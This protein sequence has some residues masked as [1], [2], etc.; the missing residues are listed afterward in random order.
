[1]QRNVW[2][3]TLCG[4]SVQQWTEDVLPTDADCA[5]CADAP[6]PAQPDAAAL[7][8]V[9]EPL[10]YLWSRDG[11]MPVDDPD[12]ETYLLDS[13]RKLAQHAPEYSDLPRAALASRVV[14]AFLAARAAAGGGQ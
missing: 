10:V 6:Q 12:T 5:A 13:A 3:R 7:R 1:M 14:D 8:A 2:H 11:D 9:L 4:A